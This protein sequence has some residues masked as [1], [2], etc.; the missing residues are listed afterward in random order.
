MSAPGIHAIPALRIAI[1]IAIGIVAEDAVRLPLWMTM[2]VTAGLVVL[3][4]LAAWRRLFREATV[5][6]VAGMLGVSLGAGKLA[7]DRGVTIA[8]PDS[9]LGR[10]GVLGGSILDPPDFMGTR[11]RFCIHGRTWTSNGVVHPLDANIVV[12]LTASR[13]DTAQ[14]PVDYGMEVHVRGVLDRPGDE[15][16]PGEFNLRKYYE[17]T[18]VELLLRARGYGNVSVADSIGGSW[19]MRVIVVPSRRYLLAHIDRTVGGEAGEFLKGLLIGERSGMSAST[20]QAFVN[21]GVAHVLAVSGSNVA[22]VAG[23]LLLLLEVLRLPRFLRFGLTLSGLLFYM[24]LT[25]S[26]P[27]VVRATIM[28]A[29]LLVGEMV[30][31]RRNPLNAVGVAALIILGVDAR[32][33]FDVGFQLSFGAVLSILVLYPQLD[34][35]IRKLKGEGFRTRTLIWILRVC[36]VS[37][38]ATLGTLPLTALYFGRVSVIGVLANI[39]VIPATGLSVVLGVVSALSGLLSTW[40]ADVYAGLNAFFLQGTLLVTTAA[41]NSPFAYIDT[42]RFTPLDSVPYYTAL[43]MVFHRANKPRARRLFILSLLAL[44]LSLFAPERVSFRSSRGVV[45]VSFIDVGEGDATLIEFPSGQTMLVDAG[46][47]TTGFDAGERT[48][49]P[50]LRRRGIASLDLFLATHAHSDHL[51]GAAAVIRDLGVHRVAA[52]G[53]REDSDIYRDFEHAVAAGGCIRDPAVAGTVL[54]GIA[55]CRVYIL[56]PQSLPGT[57][58]ADTERAGAGNESVVVKVQCGSVSFLLTG[59]AER[60]EEEA[61]GARYGDFLAS[62]ALKVGHH[63]SSTSSCREF[64]GMV[65]PSVVVISVGEGNRFRHPSP[66]VLDRLEE[67]HIPYARTD[68]EGAIIFE[69]DGV[70]LRRLPWR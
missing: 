57:A 13:R 62:T 31:E 1:L 7:M 25:G 38:V 9:V 69:S 3:L 68:E 61:L 29:V 36:A 48:V 20:R 42:L 6:L 30:Q 5:S 32:Q 53:D 23:V 8:I 34:N 44:N 35:E 66:V 54:A 2:T 39:V 11:A 49:V 40:L 16:N 18:G 15:R 17:A 52:P 65:H 56:A 45:R 26:Q 14:P 67:L 58:R 60:R 37:V 59:D 24:A 33:L 70:A 19:A 22:V 51:G 64:L 12:T 47:K 10:A 43:A 63:G 41:G 28:A 46:P 21:S 27:P 50:F 55:G 4:V